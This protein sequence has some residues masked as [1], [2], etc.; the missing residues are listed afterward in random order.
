MGT[1]PIPNQTE[2]LFWKTSKNIIE[3]I[4]SNGYMYLHSPLSTLNSRNLMHSVLGKLKYLC[5]QEFGF[6]SVSLAQSMSLYYCK[7]NQP[8]P[9]IIVTRE[10]GDLTTYAE[11]IKYLF[12]QN[13]ENGFSFHHENGKFIPPQEY[14][15]AANFLTKNDN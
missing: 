5:K 7:K 15:A 10:N 9:L 8:E 12:T 6:A 14:M 13:K 2:D 3:T 11:K 4:E 1:F